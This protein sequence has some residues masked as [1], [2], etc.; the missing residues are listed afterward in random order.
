[1]SAHTSIEFHEGFLQCL[2]QLKMYLDV[3]NHL[4][5]HIVIKELIEKDFIPKK[6]ELHTEKIEQ[7]INDMYKAYN[8]EKP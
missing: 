3:H 7:I 8:K 1:M 6:T 5:P 4:P 2:R